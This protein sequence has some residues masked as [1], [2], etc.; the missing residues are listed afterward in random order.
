MNTW[1]NQSIAELAHFLATDVAQGLADEEVTARLTR[2]GQN[3]LRKG[4]RFSALAIF[5]NQFKSLVIW[6]LIGAAAIS[7]AL[8]ETVDGIAIIA[9]VILNALIGVSRQLTCP[10]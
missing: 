9:I 3:K 1:H 10:H 7:A 4:R 5:A 8:G 2:Y 6:V